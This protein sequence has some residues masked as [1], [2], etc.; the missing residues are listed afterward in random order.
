MAARFIDEGLYLIV[1]LDWHLRDG[2]SAV[3][4][5]REVMKGG[6]SAVQLRF[7]AAS[8]AEAL[9]AARGLRALTRSGNLPFIVNDRP[10]IALLAGADGVH[11]GVDDLP[12][13]EVRRRFPGLRIGLSTHTDSQ[14]RRARGAGVAY[15]GFGPV[16][17]TRSKKS[18]YPRTGLEALERAA[19]LSA[20]PV[21]AIGGVTAR[22]CAR[23]A[24]AGVRRAA[25]LS[26]LHRSADPASAARAMHETL[27]AA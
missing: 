1:N 17:G 15:I 2:T 3:A 26:A 4:F 21:V 14:V 16:F 25:V 5:C 6:C 20:V 13:V 11:L 8:D 9:A 7:K 18:S 24:K 10:D 23:I 22:N 27:R 19:R 12:P